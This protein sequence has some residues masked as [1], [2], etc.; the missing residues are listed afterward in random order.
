VPVAAAARPC[1]GP[2]R[3]R[4]LS[5]SH[6]PPFRPCSQ[7]GCHPA[8]VERSQSRGG[9]FAGGGCGPS[10]T[11][12]A[13]PSDP[14]RPGSPANRAR[15]QPP[16]SPSSL[17]RGQLPQLGQLGQA[18]G[19]NSHRWPGIPSSRRLQQLSEAAGRI[20]RLASGFLV[21]WQPRA[22]RQPGFPPLEKGHGNG[23]GSVSFVGIAAVGRARG[24]RATAGRRGPIEGFPEGP[25]SARSA[26]SRAPTLGVSSPPSTCPVHRSGSGCRWRSCRSGCRGRLL[27]L[28]QHGPARQPVP[29]GLLV[30]FAAAAPPAFQHRSHLQSAAMPPPPGSGFASCRAPS[31]AAAHHPWLIQQATG[32][33]AQIRSFIE[34][35]TACR[36]A[37]MKRELTLLW[38][39]WP[40]APRSCRALRCRRR[41]PLACSTCRP[42]ALPRFAVLARRWAGPTGRCWCSSSSRASRLCWENPSRAA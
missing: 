15:V 26:R 13:R 22:G 32:D 20:N 19:K 31:V 38:P 29:C 14:H 34:P 27:E 5:L 11:P 28:S 39:L 23:V 41:K 4:R 16:P 18:Q 7:Q 21:V 8:L 25:C 24:P 35:V 9:V 33:S 17:E 37:T 12:P 36:V 30:V 3:V 10:E 2:S 40:S 6:R 1:P 42:V